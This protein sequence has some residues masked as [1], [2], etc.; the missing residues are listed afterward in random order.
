MKKLIVIFVLAFVAFVS[1]KQFDFGESQENGEYGTVVFDLTDRLNVR[2]GARMG[3][4]I[5]TIPE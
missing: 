5:L 3:F 2:A 4:L 1:C